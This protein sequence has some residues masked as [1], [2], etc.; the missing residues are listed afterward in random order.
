MFFFFLAHAYT[1]VKEKRVTSAVSLKDVC[2]SYGEFKAVDL[3]SIDVERGSIFGLLGPNGAGKT[4]TIRM[5][6][7]INLPDSGSISVLG[8]PVSPKLQR[9]IG[10][11]PEERGLYKKMKVQDQLLFL[12]GLKDV[13]PDESKRRIAFWADRLKIADWLEKKT[14]ELSKGMQQKIQF[15]A[16]VLHE[17]ELLILDEPFSGLDPVNTSLLIEV[18][19]ELRDKGTTIIL[20]THV[21]EQVER[22]CDDICL[23]NKARK[24]LGGNLRAIKRDY[25]IKKIAL[26]FEGDDSF[27]Q[28]PAVTSINRFANHVEVYISLPEDAQK[29]LRRAVELGVQI[30]RFELIEPSLHEIFIDKVGGQR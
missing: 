18:M 25:G 23:I 27:L 29:L 2:K 4:T 20:S 13:S 24:V 12:S 10:Y 14:D 17:P 16:T 26:D 30:R 28:D 5:I 3:L 21:M 1:Y 6:A 11:L 15:I 8:E 19:H 22:L 7:N 9:R